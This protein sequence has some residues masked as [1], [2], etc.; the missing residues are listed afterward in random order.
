RERGPKTPSSANSSG[1]PSARRRM[2]EGARDCRGSSWKSQKATRSGRAERSGV[3]GRR[4][5]G[6]RGRATR[7][8]DVGHVARVVLFGDGDGHL[9]GE[10]ELGVGFAQGGV[11]ADAAVEDEAFAVVVRAAAFLEVFEDAAV[12][13]E[14]VFEALASQEG[15]GFFAAD[16]AGAKG[17]DGPGFQL[18]GQA[19][20]GLGEFAKVF[21]VGRERAGERAEA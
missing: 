9:A 18:G 8:G 6:G 19:A 12:E 15:R 14:N 7:A 16:A 20:D 3:M 13:L 4:G 21:D 5:G 2:G 1:A 11:E 17:D 10:A